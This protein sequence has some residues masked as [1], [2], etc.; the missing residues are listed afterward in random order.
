[1]PT[2]SRRV[3]LKTEFLISDP[4]TKGL[5]ALALTDGDDHT[6]YAVN[7]DMDAYHVYTHVHPDGTFWMRDNVWCHL[8]TLTGRP[9]RLD[10]GH[11][12]VK[13][14]HQIREEVAIYFAAG[15]PAQTYAHYGASHM[16]RLWSL[17]GNNWTLMPDAVPTWHWEL[18]AE[19]VRAGGPTLPA[20]TG[21]LHYAPD[22]ARHSRA[23][24]EHLLALGATEMDRMRAENARL[25]EEVEAWHTARLNE[26]ILR[27]CL[28]PGC[29]REYD[30]NAALSGREPERPTWSG[31]GWLQVRQLDGH[32]CP[33]HAH[34]VGNQS[35]SGPH[36]PRWD[37][38]ADGAP[39]TLRCPC[40]WNSPPV[41]WRRF[42]TEAWK[43]HIAAIDAQ[44]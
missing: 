42:A 1:V 44:A 36:L 9:D 7:A 23:I 13:P 43:D 26:P 18:K 34:V 4:S 30:M 15:P 17:W 35:G 3:Y 12:D 31:T 37:Y 14:L 41:R 11:P 27:H 21:H 20:L 5:V 25:T 33:N 16:D 29:M 38:G 10:F 6:Y 39:S 28:Y 2:K 19:Q 24:H 8:P 32:I 40:G 22:G